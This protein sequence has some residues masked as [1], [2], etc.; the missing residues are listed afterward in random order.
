MRRKAGSA[1]TVF[2]NRRKSAMGS[3]AVASSASASPREGTATDAALM[4]PTVAKSGTER[5]KN[6]LENICAEKRGDV[7]F[8]VFDEE[9]ES[10]DES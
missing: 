5:F 8:F 7:V 10:D 6:A 3:G 9:G 2:F 4:S 1:P